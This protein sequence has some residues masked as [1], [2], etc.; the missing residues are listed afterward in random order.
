MTDRTH[1]A[2]EADLIAMVEHEMRNIL[3]VL[4]VSVEVVQR[5]EHPEGRGVDR[6]LRQARQLERLVTDLINAHQIDSGRLQLRRERSDLIAVLRACVD[7]AASLSPSHAFFIEAP[8][9]PLDGLWD[10]D[11]LTQVIRNLLSNAIKYSPRGGKVLVKLEASERMVAV[12]IADHGVGIAPDAVP[13]LFE[14]FYRAPGTAGNV[15]GMG[16]GLHVCKQLVE[17]HEGTISVASQLG[18]GTTITFR[19]SRDGTPQST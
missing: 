1:Q 19:L 12:S 2:F 15:R 18:E 10:G 4:L 8:V 13:R 9:G 16:V 5:S 17:A 7:E 3:Q 6:I 14:R 11:R